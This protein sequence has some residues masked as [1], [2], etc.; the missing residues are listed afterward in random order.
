MN[1]KYRFPVDASST[2]YT[3]SELVGVVSQNVFN[4][5]KLWLNLK[6]PIS[7]WV[8]TSPNFYA[9]GNSAYVNEH[10]LLAGLKTVDVLVADESGDYYGKAQQTG[11]MFRLVKRVY[12]AATNY[13]TDVQEALKKAGAEDLEGVLTNLGNEK[14][15][16]LPSIA[17]LLAIPGAAI[18]AASLMPTVLTVTAIEAL[19]KN[20]R[21]YGTIRS[22]RQT[23]SA[24]LLSCIATAMTGKNMVD[25]NRPRYRY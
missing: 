3:L 13:E 11:R 7:E 1:Q 15:K 8:H 16:Q 10:Y 22:L 14:Q 24:L 9:V 21:F 5:K 12:A 4:R 23:S 18:L 2:A 20:S 17:D 6:H 25:Y 19:A